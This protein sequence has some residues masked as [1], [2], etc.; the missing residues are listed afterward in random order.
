MSGGNEEFATILVGRSHSKCPG[1]TQ[2]RK[3]IE[4]KL[5]EM[6]KTG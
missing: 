4:E 3:Q 6:V 5:C 1:S 2:K